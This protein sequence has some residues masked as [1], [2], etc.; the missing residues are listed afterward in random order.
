VLAL[1]LITSAAACVLPAGRSFYAPPSDN[2]SIPD[3]LSGVGFSPRSAQPYEIIDFFKK[4][5]G[6]GNVLVWSGDW[7]EFEYARGFPTLLVEQS[8][9]NGLTSVIEVTAFNQSGGKLLRSL[10]DK[11]QQKYVAGAA[12]FASRYQPRYLGLGVD[13]DVL[14]TRS[15]ADFDKF[16]KIFDRTYDAVKA[17]SP[18]TNIFTIFQLEKMKGL[19]GGLYGG[20]NDPSKNLWFLLDRFP[21]ADLIAFNTYPGMIYETPSDIPLDYFTSI[22]SHTGKPL[23]ISGTG[24]QSTGV[25]ADRPGSEAQQAEYAQVFLAHTADLKQEFSA[26]IYL[27]DP[28]ILQ[29]PF[30]SMGLLRGDGTPRPA[31]YV[32]S[33]IQ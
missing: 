12:D 23:A 2:T 4:A 20:A 9:L 29:E 13:A 17:V 28:T 8:Y 27:Y 3:R 24:W 6:A 32:W 16:V 25:S 15:P 30:N 11:T 31:W 33:T 1:A 14:Y 19:N 22:R 7:K 5:R 10:D 18:A 26:W 21:K